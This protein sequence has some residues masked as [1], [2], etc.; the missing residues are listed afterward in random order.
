MTT[1][2]D[3]KAQENA[4]V[5]ALFPDTFNRWRDRRPREETER[6]ASS[7]FALCI[8]GIRFDRALARWRAAHGK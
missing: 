4:T 7:T 1:R 6:Q 8:R 3:A 2:P 5:I